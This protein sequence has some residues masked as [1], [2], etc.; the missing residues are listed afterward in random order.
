MSRHAALFVP[1]VLFAVGLA[2]SGMT[3]PGKVVGF[4][5]FAGAWDPS[6]AFVMT[7]ATATFSVI[8]VLAHR[9]QKPLLWGKL[10]GIRS[11][12]NE[13][14]SRLFIGTAMFGIGWGLSGMCPGPSLTNLSRLTPDV[15]AFVT[16]M[17]VGMVIAQRVFGVDR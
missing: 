1:G 7:G 3:N 13:L 10:P 11:V 6:L 12:A 15:L 16:A 2:I 9:R 8:S 17:I 14:D 5:D 4:L